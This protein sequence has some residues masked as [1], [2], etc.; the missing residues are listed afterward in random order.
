MKRMIIT[1]KKENIR[2]ETK[3][4]RKR[5]VQNDTANQSRVFKNRKKYDRRAYKQ[6]DYS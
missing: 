5:R 3:E 2:K 1:I 4:E 6:F